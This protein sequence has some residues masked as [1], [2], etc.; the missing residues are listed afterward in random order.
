[1]YQIETR[2]G[3]SQL[4]SKGT[5]SPAAVI[6]LFQDCSN[7]QSMSIGEDVEFFKRIHRA[8]ILSSWQII[9]D[10]LPGLGEE[11]VV[12]TAAYKFTS[13]FG[14][15]NFQLAT[16]AGKV[17]AKANSN[18]VYVDADTKKPL[19]ITDDIGKPYYTGDEPLDMEYASRKVPVPKE[20]ETGKE[21]P[22]MKYHLDTNNHVNNACYVQFALEY[23]PENFK[24]RQMRVEYR[25]SAVYGDVIL[26][27]YFCGDA[28]TTVVLKNREDGST[29][30]VVLI[31]GGEN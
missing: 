27:Y 30:A 4:D 21:F 12:S 2:I 19:R 1:M 6:D 26:P 25:Q 11:V 16:K 29:F 8:W 10:E 20:L 3:Y 9:F 31:E 14:L 5:L 13:M 23:V 28:S 24:I 15:R 22:V 7:F 18:W 17:L